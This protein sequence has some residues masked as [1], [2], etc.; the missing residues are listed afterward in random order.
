MRGTAGASRVE[1]NA[2]GRVIRELGRDPGTP[3]QD[4]YLTIDSELQRYAAARLGD[5]SAACVVMDVTN[6]DVLALVSTPG[7]DPN[8]FNVGIT[9]AQWKALTDRRPHA[10]DQQGDRAAPIRRARPSSRSWRW[11][12]STAGAIDENFTVNCTGSLTFGNHDFHCWKHGGHGHVDLHRGIAAFLRHLFLRSGAAARH[13]RA[14][15]PARTQ[16][17]LGQPTGI[18]IPGESAGFIPSR[19]WKLAKFGMPW[20]QGETLEHRHRPGL[21]DWRRRSSS[22]LLAARI[23]SGKAVVPRIAHVVGRRGAAAAA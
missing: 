16:L 13:R 15:K 2:Y 14:S 9:D 5:E 7:F 17:G 18:E 12:R 3:G 20:Q 21:C 10:A 8:L 1:V 4:I 22:A 23:A 19:A 11:R 6:G